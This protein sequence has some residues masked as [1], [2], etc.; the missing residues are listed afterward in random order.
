MFIKERLEKLT[1][2]VASS[3]EGPIGAPRG[4]MGTVSRLL[5]ECI[6]VFWGS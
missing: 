3:G 6:R 1:V 4:L 5:Q 2:I